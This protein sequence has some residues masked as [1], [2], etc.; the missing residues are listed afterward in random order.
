M[1]WTASDPF[2]D[3]YA[4]ADLAP[5]HDPA[6]DEWHSRHYTPTDLMTDREVIQA[7]A[8]GDLAA[9]WEA[10]WRGL[11][12]TTPVTIWSRP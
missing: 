7:A 3:S 4:D 1:S 2:T 8:D 9:G 11:H 6:D 10:A 5:F 12:D